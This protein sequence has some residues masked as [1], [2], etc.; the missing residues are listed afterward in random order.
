MAVA[1]TESCKAS[2]RGLFKNTC[3]LI[4]PE[5]TAGSAEAAKRVVRCFPRGCLA[6]V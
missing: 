3:Q 2:L 1:A 5:L 4:T 6:F